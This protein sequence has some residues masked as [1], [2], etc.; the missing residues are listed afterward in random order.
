[1]YA[2]LLELAFIHLR[3]ITDIIVVLSRVFAANLNSYIAEALALDIGAAGASYDNEDGDVPQSSLSPLAGPPLHDGEAGAGGG[4]SDSDNASEG[5]G[6]ALTPR[7]RGLGTRNFKDLKGGAKLV[8]G[9]GKGGMARFNRLK[10]SAKGVSARHQAT[11]A[12]PRG[13]AVQSW[14]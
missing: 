8:G 7:S 4:G 9:L 3:C 11:F 10:K 13:N 2:C 6:D 1:M 14:Q 12:S 5:E